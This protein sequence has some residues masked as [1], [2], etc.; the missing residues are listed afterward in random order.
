M[1]CTSIDGAALGANRA[2]RGR[3]NEGLAMKAAGISLAL[4]AAALTGCSGASSLPS[5]P[6]LTTGSI[7]GRQTDGCGPGLHQRPDEPR[8]PGRDGIRQ[9]NQVRVQLRPRQAQE[10]LPYLRAHA[11]PRRRPEQGRE[12]LRRLVQRRHQGGRRRSRLLLGRE[13]Q[14]HQGRLDPPPRRRLH[15]GRAA[16]GSGQ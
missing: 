2:T 8:V 3:R 15:A 9:G 5:L 12:D 16:E 7:L 4:V 1:G 10:Q 11:H 6:S 13:D 14:G